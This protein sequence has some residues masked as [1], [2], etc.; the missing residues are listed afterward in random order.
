MECQKR[1]EKD[2]ELQKKR[3]E[4][5][6]KPSKGTT[7]SSLLEFR[8]NEIT[9]ATK[10]A[11]KVVKKLSSDYKGEMQRFIKNVGGMLTQNVLLG[12][13][14]HELLPPGYNGKQINPV[15]KS[16]FLTGC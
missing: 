2:K 9:N 10:T 1:H 14:I 15:F 7:K 5:L 4:F 16:Y 12:Y 11:S 13:A 3:D 8:R 6:E